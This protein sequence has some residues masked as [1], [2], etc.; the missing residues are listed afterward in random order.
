VLF[1]LIQKSGSLKFLK[2]AILRDK[3]ATVA[4]I[5][6][7]LGFLGGLFQGSILIGIGSAILWAIIFFIVR[8]K[9]PPYA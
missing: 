7:P 3:F 1:L 8:P 6:I 2:E 5:F 4:A 9:N